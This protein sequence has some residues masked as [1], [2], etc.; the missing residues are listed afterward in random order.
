V[1]NLFLH[2][3]NPILRSITFTFVLIQIPRHFARLAELNVSNKTDPSV[4]ITDSFVWQ[5]ADL[6]VHHRVIER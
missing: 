2:C 1:L 4:L 5:S 6:S 3:E